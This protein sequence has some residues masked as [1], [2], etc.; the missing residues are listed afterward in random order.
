MKDFSCVFG[1]KF[2]KKKKD[3][4]NKGIGHCTITESMSMQVKNCKGEDQPSEEQRVQ[5]RFL[6]TPDNVPHNRLMSKANSQ[7]GK[8][9]LAN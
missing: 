2:K 7:R 3:E 6:E 9:K 4:K 5:I 8:E 1:G